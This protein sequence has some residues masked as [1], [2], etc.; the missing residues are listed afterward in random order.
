MSCFTVAVDARCLNRPH[1]RGIGRYLR[2]LI[3][4]MAPEDDVAWHL[5]GDRP[6]LPFHLPSRPGVNVN[7]FDCRGYRIHAWEQFALPRNVSRLGPDLL[8][9]PATS[10]PWFQPVPTVVTVHDTVPWNEPDDEW[11]PGWYRDRVLP[12]ALEKCKAI[13]TVS[14]NSRRDIE[15]LWPSLSQKIHVIPHGIDT[16][17]SRW[18]PAR[19]NDELAQLGVKSPFLLYVGGDIPRKRP[20]WA[21]DI[22]ASIGDEESSLVLC[23][24]TPAGQSVLTG[25]LE[26]RLRPRVIFLPFVSE[27]SM[28]DL[29]GH[30]IAV[31]YP[32]LYEGFGFPMLEAQAVGTPVLFTPFGSLAELQG[33][34][35]ISMTPY[36]R[37]AWTATCRLLLRERRTSLRQDQQ[38]REWARRFSWEAAAR[39]TAEVYASVIVPRPM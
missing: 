29:Y 24:V 27:E 31:L 2:S 38:A 25:R 18:Q 20:E 33:P 30:A 22:F 8:H 13:V 4:A 6:D 3:E 10:L 7:L 36:D 12:G 23:G 11:Q 26:P 32:T 9:A 19:L 39:R 35:A 5:F 16:R 28:A 14:A 34:G 37:G 15:R 17:F 1:V 21:L